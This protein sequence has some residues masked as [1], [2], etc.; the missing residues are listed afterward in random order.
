MV[1]TT[2]NFSKDK[3]STKIPDSGGTDHNISLK[4][5]CSVTNPIFILN[6]DSTP[7][8]NYCHYIFGYYFVDDIIMQNRNIYE[9]HCSLDVLGTYRNDIL[10]SNQ[11]VLRSA[12][13]YNQFLADVEVQPALNQIKGVWDTEITEFRG[14]TYI[15][16]VLG[17]SADLSSTSYIGVP[18]YILT[19][20]QIKQFI[21]V[22]FDQP[23]YA[24]QISSIQDFG[25][26]FKC[27]LFNPASNILRVNWVPVNILGGSA[28]R[29]YVG[30]LDTGIDAQTLG[31]E[32]VSILGSITPPSAY[33]SDWRDFD[34]RFTQFELSIPSVGVIPVNPADVYAGISYTINLEFLTG[35]LVYFLYNTQTNAIIGKYTTQL[36]TSVQIGG[37][38]GQSFANS[39]S[40]GVSA[41]GQLVA[42]SPSMSY[43]AGANA[44]GSIGNIIHN[45][46]Q[47]TFTS[48]GTAGS[49]QDIKRDHTFRL[50][51][52]IFGSSGYATTKTGRPLRENR[53]LSNLSGFCQCE[54]AKLDTSAY[55]Q[56][57]DDIIGHMNS[58]FFI[59]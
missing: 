51:R 32:G 29:L 49:Q 6:Y 20:D 47:P 15:V 36:N 12:S 41:I 21:K 43:G 24:S 4:E 44:L 3:N 38:T 58:G 52:R 26:L 27:A 28:T 57:K 7:T 54:N 48:I 16:Q 13:D 39:L 56:I 9:V 30:K 25:E 46:L 18:T 5:N 59:E 55:G 34:N 17:Y 31:N 45:A 35:V 37:D 50:T 2:Y 42:Q 33:F 14:G 1:L 53:T 19:N 10:G 22:C 40:S 23:V 8:F 11:F